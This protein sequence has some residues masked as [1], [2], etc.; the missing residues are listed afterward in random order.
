MLICSLKGHRIRGTSLV[1][2][3]EFR[4]VSP[5]ENFTAPGGGHYG[6]QGGFAP[7]N[8]YQMQNFNYFQ[9]VNFGSLEGKSPLSRP[10]N[11]SQLVTS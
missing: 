3:V 11:S 5:G 2:N 4:N 6:D 8:H 1:T 9:G 10:L 7:L